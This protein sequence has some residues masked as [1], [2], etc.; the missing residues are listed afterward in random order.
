MGTEKDVRISTH[1]TYRK[2]PLGS[3]AGKAENASRLKNGTLLSEVKNYN[4]TN[5]LL[6]AVLIG[7]FV[8]KIADNFDMPVS[9][10][11]L[12]GYILCGV[13]CVFLTNILFV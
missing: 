1:S 7:S 13:Y 5:S 3:I 9:F 12:L 4:C 2:K 6:K 10:S 8:A 11:R